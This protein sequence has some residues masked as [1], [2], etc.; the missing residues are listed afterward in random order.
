MFFEPT[1]CY[2][3]PGCLAAE[4]DTKTAAH[5]GFAAAIG[6]VAES[7]PGP[8]VHPAVVVIWIAGIADGTGHETAVHAEAVR[9]VKGAVEAFLPWATR[10]EKKS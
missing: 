9:I 5:D 3:A 6:V 10:C 2:M 8:Q 7:E 1:D 4:Q